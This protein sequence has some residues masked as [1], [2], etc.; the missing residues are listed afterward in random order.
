MM[1]TVPASAIKPKCSPGIPIALSSKPSALKST[2][3]SE[4]PRAVESLSLL[5]VVLIRSVRLNKK[6]V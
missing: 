4:L 2:F 5:L 6:V 3:I 1:C